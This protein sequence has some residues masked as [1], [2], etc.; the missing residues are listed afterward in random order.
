MGSF[1]FEGS[2]VSF[3]E[4]D[5]VASALYRDGLRTFSRSMKYH[6]RRGLYCGT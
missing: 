4:G 3:G 2:A 5:T 1:E 6:R